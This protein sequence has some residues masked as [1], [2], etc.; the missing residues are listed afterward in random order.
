M[1]VYWLYSALRIS[2]IYPN[3]KIAIFEKNNYLGGRLFTVSFKHKNQI[4]Q[5]EAGGGRF[6]HQ[7]K[8]LQHLIERFNMKKEIVKITNERVPIVRSLQFSN[9]S[10]IYDVYQPEDHEILDINWIL[11]Y[12][13]KKSKKYKKSYL[14]TISFYDLVLKVVSYE[15][16]QFLLD[17]FGYDA[18]LL[19]VNANDGIRM[20]SKDFDVKNQYYILKTGFSKLIGKIV[21]ELGKRNIVIYKNSEIKEFNFNKQVFNLNIQQENL[22]KIKQQT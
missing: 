3:K 1:V 4:Y 20:F 21:K 12:T 8:L 14:Q 10:Q 17:A 19:E 18:E 6:A 11:N 16:A 7:H 15:C 13:I 2:D 9:K 22:I 5:Y